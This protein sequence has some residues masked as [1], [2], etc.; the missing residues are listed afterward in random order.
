MAQ[1]GTSRRFLAIMAGTAGLLLAG[2]VNFSALDDLKQASP[3][4]GSPFDQALFQDYA[5]LARSFGDVG[6]ASYTAFDRDG[7]LSLN[8]S[9]NDVAALA[10][11]YASKALLLTRG[12]LA[13]VE[14]SNDL[15]SHA[16]RDR[17]VRALDPG[18]DVFAR[19]AARAQADYDCWMM[20]QTVPSQGPAAAAC[21]AAL[22]VSLPRLEAEVHAIPQK[23]AAAATPAASGPAQ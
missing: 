6:Q 1:N 12:E 13:E 8:N 11:A 22:D 19:D 3:P 17:L 9:D 20:N 23:P 21:R 10:N 14:P 5:F 18:R 4:T 15:Q 16:L 7:S 2:C